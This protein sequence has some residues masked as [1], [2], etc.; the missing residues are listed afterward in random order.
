MEQ[1]IEDTLVLLKKCWVLVLFA[2]YAACLYNEFRFPGLRQEP[3]EGEEIL[4]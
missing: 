3:L 2:L 1:K 4:W